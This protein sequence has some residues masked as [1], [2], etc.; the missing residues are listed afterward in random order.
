MPTAVPVGTLP[1]APDRVHATCP[2]CGADRAAVERTVR[3]H[4]G[5]ESFAVARCAAC[6]TRYVQDPP[7]PA[8]I[9]GY[10]ETPAGAAMHQE[11]GRLFAALRDRR[12][13]ADVRPLLER[14][15]PGD[16]VADLGTGDGSV[17]RHLQRRK[18]RAVGFDVFPP[19]AWP[20]ATIPYRTL[21]LAA[22]PPAPAAL[23][24]AGPLRGAV[25][26]HVL[27][28]VHR[29]VEVL[30][31]LREAGV[32]HVLVIVPNAGSRL[33]RRLGD[34]WY[35]WDPPRH[36]TFF[37]PATL[38]TCAAAAGFRVGFSRTYGLDEVATS[39]HR[40]SLLRGTP[41][42]RR[43]AHVLRPT[44]LVAGGLSVLSAPVLDSVVHAVLDPA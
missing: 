31:A 16:G 17:A 22:G 23:T 39:A 32:E 4:M 24:S 7:S 28:H 8:A 11:P 40:A 19:E 42:A 9:G 33:A 5:T 27:E 43:A 38:A 12:I 36:L 37:E 25:M 20:H 15:R 35:Y 13:A 6:A 29:P 14:L 3:D 26:R 18:L 21:D 2:S 1:G 30:G 34:A 41:R 10:Y 44:G